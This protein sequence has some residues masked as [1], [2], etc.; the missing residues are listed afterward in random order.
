MKRL[1][2]LD[3]KSNEMENLLNGS[4]DVVIRA[5][6]IKKYPFGMIKEGYELVFINNNRENIVKASS[7]VKRA[8]F[9]ET[10]S[11]EETHDIL[12]K[13][14]SRI[15]L[16]KERCNYISERKYISIFELSHIKKENALL[17]RSS[18]GKDDDWIVLHD[19]V[20][21]KV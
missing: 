1:L 3:K 11:K 10:K 5:A 19:I 2:Y 21:D 4:K 14:K 13:Y 20:D 15:L 9:I 6:N 16:S 8:I 17:E 7:I 18:Y 12:E